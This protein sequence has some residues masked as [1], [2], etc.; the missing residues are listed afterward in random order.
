MLLH[1]LIITS[2]EPPEGLEP[3]PD[4]STYVYLNASIMLLW[5]YKIARGEVVSRKRDVDGN[6]IGCENA[7]PILDSNWYKVEFDNGEVIEFTANVIVE[8]MYAQCDKN[9]NYLLIIEYFID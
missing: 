6:P 9:R 5:G 3:A 2:E 8:R 7:N 1:R 4:L